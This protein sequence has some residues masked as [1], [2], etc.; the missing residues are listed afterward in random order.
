MKTYYFGICDQDGVG[1]TELDIQAESLEKAEAI[2]ASWLRNGDWIQ[3][4]RESK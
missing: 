4:V 3:Y 2:A 1:V